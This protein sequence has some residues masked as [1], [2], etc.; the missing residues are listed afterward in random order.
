MADIWHTGCVDAGICLIPIVIGVAEGIHHLNHF[1]AEAGWVRLKQ[2]G[3]LHA[4]V[5]GDQRVT[6]LALEHGSLP[7]LYSC[8][9]VA[10]STMGTLH[11]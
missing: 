2:S 6:S 4:Y 3:A 7:R 9:T 10:M 8:S 5:L 11:G 1:G